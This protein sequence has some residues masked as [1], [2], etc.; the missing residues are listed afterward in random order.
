MVVPFCKIHNDSSVD[1]SQDGSLVAVFVPS[2]HGFPMDAQL[3]VISLRPESYLQCIY[4]RKY[5]MRIFSLRF[6]LDFS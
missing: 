2:E 1:V 4:S 3:Q 6:V 5:G